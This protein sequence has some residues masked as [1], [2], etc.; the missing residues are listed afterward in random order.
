M[1]KLSSLVVVLTFAVLSAASGGVERSPGPAEEERG[2]VFYW[3]V[4]SSDLTWGEECSDSESL[5]EDVGP[6][7][8]EENSYLIYEVSDDGTEAVAMDCTSTDAS[9]CTESDLD[10]RF[11]IDGSTLKYQ[12]EPDVKDIEGSDCDLE[13]TQTWTIEDQGETGT[14]ALDVGFALIGDVD[15]CAA[16]QAA[17]EAQSDNG[18]GLD[19]CVVTYDIGLEYTKSESR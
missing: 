7:E 15:D 12:P 13:G 19:G 2:E 3:L 6:V 17:L 18:K 11:V 8:F 16:H 10:I 14:F 4:T 5:R 9:S 1:Q